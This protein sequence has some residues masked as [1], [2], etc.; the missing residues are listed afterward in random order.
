MKQFTFPL[1]PRL[2]SLTCVMNDARLR[3]CKA[4][5]GFH[6]E[7]RRSGGRRAQTLSRD[8]R[9]KIPF[10]ESAQR[11]GHDSPVQGR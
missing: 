3:I 11:G 2:R 10:V 4:T 8:F 9:D 6:L 5:I 7:S 1:A